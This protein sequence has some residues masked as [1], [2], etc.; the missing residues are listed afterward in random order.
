M[1]PGDR[2]TQGP[3]LPLKARTE[4]D[5]TPSVVTFSWD[6]RQTELPPVTLPKHEKRTSSAR[7]RRRMASP[8]TPK[9]R[10]SPYIQKADWLGE[11]EP[12]HGE[13]GDSQGSGCTSRRCYQLGSIHRPTACRTH[14]MTAVL[15]LLYRANC[16]G[17]V[18]EYRLMASWMTSKG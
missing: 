1:V 16:T 17:S 7:E 13:S 18:R 2:G 4:K 11:G 3:L 6:T 10:G 5:L 8:V 15:N 9:G 12:P 14:A